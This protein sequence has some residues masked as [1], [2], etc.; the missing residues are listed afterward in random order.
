MDLDLVFL[1][2]P[3][4][5][6]MSFVRDHG[7][8]RFRIID[9]SGD[10]RLGTA[11]AYERWYGQPHVVPEFL[12]EAVFGLPELNRRSIKS[13]RLV[14]NPGCY[15]T[16]STLALVPL[17]KHGLIDPAGI[18]IDAKSGVS[19]AG[20]KAKAATHFPDVF[21]NF[22]AYALL[23]HRHTPE[24]EET[25]SRVAGQDV[26]LLFTPHLLPID[27]GILVTAYAL[28][29]EGV[30]D[31]GLKAAYHDFYR[32]EPFVRV[33]DAPPAVKQVR[34]SNFCDVFVAH[35]ARTGRVVALSVLD[36]LVKG[37]AGQA[38]Q[39]MN[40]M[41]GLPERTGLQQGPLHP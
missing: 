20:A 3:H 15:P 16:A 14:G 37:A 7:I 30:D 38:V 29:A 35:D 24:I 34:G 8:A 23:G 40:L 11:E 13:A 27:R 9:L 36:N 2:L 21:G 12:G 1:A 28:G 26:Q 22:K 18:V 25:L 17:L 5:V 10:F 19:G 4:G 31:A 41:F 39:N 32:D 33:V 6:S